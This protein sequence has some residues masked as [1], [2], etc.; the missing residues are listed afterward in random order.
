MTDVP[1]AEQPDATPSAP[2]YP[3]PPPPPPAG[4]D[5]ETGLALPDGVELASHG[6]RI[7]AFFLAIPL[8][9]VTLFIGYIIWGAIVWSKGTSPALQVLG[10]KAYNPESGRPANWGRMALRNIVGGIV[11]GICTIVYI[12]SFAMF[13]TGK[14]RKTIADHIG[15]TVVIYDPKKVFP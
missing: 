5:A 4:Y 15:G 14:Q 11:Q 3:P 7:G 12:V 8:M 1:P 6:R 13:L 2:A 10:M 9:I